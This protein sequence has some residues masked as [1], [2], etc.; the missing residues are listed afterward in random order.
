MCFEFDSRPPELPPELVLPKLAGASGAEITEIE[1]ADGTRFAAALAAG[2]GHGPAVV[3]LPDVRGLYPFYVELAERFAAA[4]TSA[5]AIDYFG[6]TGGAE[7]RGEDFDFMQHLPATT[8]DQVQL[9]TAA[10]WDAIRDR[11][12]ASALITVGFCFGGAHSFLAATNAELGLDA[13]IGFY[14]TLDPERIGMPFAMPAP[15]KHSTKTRCGV[16]GLFGG[17]DDF[18]PPDDIERFD[19]DLTAAGVDHELVVYRG[20]PHSFFDRSAAEHAAASQ[21][22]WRRVIGFIQGVG[23][24]AA[25]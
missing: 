17:A 12:G 11:T 24:T 21:D 25:A 14:G 9:D 2:E 6:R 3:I 18:I 15:L 19:Q 5:V 7:V 16:L 20:A 22:A 1:S 23:G 8:P 13:A 4:G 10:A